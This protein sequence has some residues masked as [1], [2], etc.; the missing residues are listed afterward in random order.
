[1]CV[2]VCMQVEESTRK[3]GLSRDDGRAEAQAEVDAARGR[4]KGLDAQ[5]AAQGSEL[6]RV[7]EELASVAGRLA[8]ALQSAQ[9][10]GWG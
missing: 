6:Q 1:M 2:Y 5:V 3:A 10:R 7:K 9:V 8:S 4:V